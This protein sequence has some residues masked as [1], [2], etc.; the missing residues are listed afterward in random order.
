MIARPLVAAALLTLAAVPASAQLV[1]RPVPN[2]GVE[3]F[4][5]QSPSMGVRFS[6]N[7]GM[8]ADY[9]PGDGKRYPA[10]IVT[11]GDFTF[12]NV[13]A[14]AASLSGVI[15]PL[16]VISVGTALT[17]GEAEHSRRRIY[18]FSPPGWDRKDAFGELVSGFCKTLQ[19][20]EGRC[21]GG[22]AKFLTAIATEMLPLL[23]AKFPIDTT[24]L[25]L[26]GL[27]AGGFFTSWAVFQPNSPFTRYII[28][29]PA[30][31]YGRG[32]IFRQ[33]AAY[34][35]THKDL[36]VGIYLAAGVLEATDP[37]LEGIGE[38]VSGMSHLAGTLGGRNYPGL[39]LTIEF[40]PGMGHSDVMAASVVRG[41]RTLYAK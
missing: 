29:S 6:L 22:S 15:K 14:A 39:K 21:T 30:M 26:F 3:S 11:D 18:E 28:S 1:A 40:H 32:E 12:G 24:Q 37:Q 16:F 19:S 27:S 41:L 31:S 10:L 17:E 4:T 8:P 13:F 5:F 23:A 34:A 7:V 2:A 38:I 36:P 33:E 35:A 9:K 20:P 25:G